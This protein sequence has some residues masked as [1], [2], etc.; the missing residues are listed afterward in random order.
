MDQARTARELFQAFHDCALRRDGNAFGD[1][2]AENATM[3]FPFAPEG[4]LLRFVGREA[5]RR[6]ATEAWARSLLSP[7]AFE[8]VV[9]TECNSEVLVA[10]YEVR[11]RSKT[12]ATFAVKAVMVLR[13]NEGL[14]VSMR[15]YLDPLAI[16]QASRRPPQGRS[17]R[18][19]LRLYHLAML[20]KSA[21]DLADL[22]ARDA[23]H[24]F[25]FFTPNSAPFLESREAVRAA[26]RDG[27]RNHPLAIDAI[28]EVFSHEATDPEVVMGQWRARATV[29]ATGK[30]V[31]ITGVLV[32]RV[33]DGLIVHARDFMDALGIANALGRLPFAPPVP[34]D[35]VSQRLS[36]PP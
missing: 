8:S 28:E 18:D 15:E 3:E 7:E 27:W 36:V 12:G 17:P 19:V 1:L 35:N 30:R 33:R 6:R 22:Y 5:I 9:L 26:Y 21:D 14:I 24:E 20:T 2:F 10:E 32:L 16:A 11:G 23:I 25:S 34:M 31:D 4:D 29:S 13:T